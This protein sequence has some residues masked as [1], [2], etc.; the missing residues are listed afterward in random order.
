LLLLFFFLALSKFVV[1]FLLSFTLYFTY[2]K[3]CKTKR[4]N[5][6]WYLHCRIYYICA[7]LSD[8]RNNRTICSACVYNSKKCIDIFM[9]RFVL[10]NKYS[11]K[12]VHSRW[13]DTYELMN[14]E[15]LD[16]GLMPWCCRNNNLV[17]FELLLKGCAAFRNIT[18]FLKN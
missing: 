17:E 5:W 18:R 4:M 2:E 11:T 1:F 14:W 7:F 8:S 12:Y 3:K 10:Y 9:L 6:S 15:T 13:Y 16:A